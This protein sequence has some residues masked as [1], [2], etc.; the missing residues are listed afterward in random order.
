MAHAH[1]R[2]EH[3]IPAWKRSR[4]RS[5]RPRP[6][7]KQTPRARFS[8]RD[9]R[10]FFTGKSRFIFHFY[11]A[12][13]YFGVRA[14]RSAAWPRCKI[15]PSEKQRLASPREIPL[16]NSSPP[17]CL[18]VGCLTASFL[19]W[20]WRQ[21]RRRRKK[22]KMSYRG[23]RKFDTTAN[24]LSNKL[25]EIVSCNFKQDRVPVFREFY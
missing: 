20:N 1:Q 11:R 23:R 9:V 19:T 22:Y 13:P 8:P 12:S 15:C 7:S 10:Y 5:K 14:P 21:R 2:A 6:S 16:Q 3:F 25:C 17:L 4:F 24:D 18:R